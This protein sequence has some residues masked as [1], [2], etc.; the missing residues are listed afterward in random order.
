MTDLIRAIKRAREAAADRQLT[1]AMRWD[2]ECTMN[3]LLSVSRGQGLHFEL[4]GQSYR[5]E[6]GGA[7]KTIHVWANI[8]RQPRKP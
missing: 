4:I 5:L 1:G 6:L 2:V 3:E 7:R 8:I